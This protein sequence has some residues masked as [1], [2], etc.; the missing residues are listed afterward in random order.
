MQSLKIQFFTT[1]LTG[2]TDLVFLYKKFA[3]YAKGK[4]NSLIDDASATVQAVL[5][6]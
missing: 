4:D 1:S 2:L 5:P 6:H 3:A